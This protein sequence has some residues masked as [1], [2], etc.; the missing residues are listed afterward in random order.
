[1]NKAVTI[2]R[3]GDAD[4]LVLTE[5]PIVE[6][7][8]HEV[9]IA[10][11]AAGLNFAEVSARQGLYPEAPKPPCVVGYELAGVVDAVG[12]TGG[13]LKVGDRV[14]ALTKFGGHASFVNVSIQQCFLI[15]ENMSFATAAAIPVNYLTAHHMLFHV[16]TVHPSSTVLLH[17]AAGGVGT[18]VCPC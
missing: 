12:D 17:M 18:A 14:L 4:V 11:R 2:T 5:R 7:K 6:P 1:M 16:G 3:H 13:N 9:R 15:P 8:G 10:V